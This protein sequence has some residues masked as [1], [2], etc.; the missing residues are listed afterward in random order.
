MLWPEREEGRNLESSYMMEDADGIPVPKTPGDALMALK[1][2]LETDKALAIIWALND[3]W[4]TE[5]ASYQ[6]QNTHNKESFCDILETLRNIKNERCFNPSQVEHVGGSSLA[7][8]AE[9]AKKSKA[10]PKADKEVQ[11]SKPQESTSDI[12]HLEERMEEM[13][14]FVKTI[15]RYNCPQR[16]AGHHCACH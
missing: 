6:T 1:T 5:K 3:R 8:S 2:Y 12:S 13:A 7:L 15:F 14:L 16:H 4:S 11:P 9:Q 10:A